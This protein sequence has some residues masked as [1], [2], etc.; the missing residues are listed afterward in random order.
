[1]KGVASGFLWG[2]RGS[3]NLVTHWV[4]ECSHTVL[5]LV[6]CMQTHGRKRVRRGGGPSMWVEGSLKCSCACMG[7]PDGRGPCV[8]EVGTDSGGS[9]W[10]RPFWIVY[11]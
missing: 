2:V 5:N 11:F 3:V 10:S 1:M 7:V 8:G 9:R 4:S 6:T